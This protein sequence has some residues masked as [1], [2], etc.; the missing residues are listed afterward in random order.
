MTQ[1]KVDGVKLSKAL[2]QFSSLDKSIQAMKEK[3]K[4][5]KQYTVKLQ[6]IEDSL[7]KQVKPLP[8]VPQLELSHCVL[9]QESPH[10]V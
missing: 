6:L 2:E 4:K 8:Q 1:P 9:V 3:G 10:L 7:L 5:L